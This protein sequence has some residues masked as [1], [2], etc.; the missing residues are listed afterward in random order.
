MIT[1][2]AGAPSTTCSPATQQQQSANAIATSHLVA[3][4]HLQ[5][6]LNE[7]RYVKPLLSGDDLIKMDAPQGPQVKEMLARLL[8]SRLDGKVKSRE[9]EE[10]FVRS[11]FPR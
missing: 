11:N 7:L 5:L 2:P 10:Q 4:R 8:D 6:F 3:R 9:D 1:R